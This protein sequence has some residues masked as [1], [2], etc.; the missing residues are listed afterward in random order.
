[1]QM[2][3]K[4]PGSHVKTVRSHIM[5]FFYK[6]F[7][8][9]PDLRERT[10]VTNSYDGFEEIVAELKARVTDDS[11]FS[12]VIELRCLKLPLMCPKYLRNLM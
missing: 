7:L 9:H 4:Y 12:E 10:A 3:H 8:K 2:C 11:E 1:M 5:K 6:Y